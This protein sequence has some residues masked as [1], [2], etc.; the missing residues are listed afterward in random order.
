MTQHLVHNRERQAV[1]GELARVLTAHILVLNLGNLNDL[2]TRRAHTVARSHFLIKRIDRGV[3]RGFTVLLVG[4][5]ETRARLVANPDAEVLHGGGV[6]LEDL[7]EIRAI[8]TQ[9]SKRQSHILSSRSSKVHHKSLARASN[10]AARLDLPRVVRARALSP[11]PIGIDTYLVAS[12]DLTVRLLHLFEARH[13]IPIHINISS[14]VRVHRRTSRRVAF[15]HPSSSSRPSRRIAQPRD[16]PKLGARLDVI[17]RPKLHAENLRFGVGF[18][19]HVTAN[20]L[21]L[22]VLRDVD[23]THATVSRS[24]ANPKTLAHIRRCP[25]DAFPRRRRRRRRPHR[26]IQHADIYTRARVA[27]DVP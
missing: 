27:R 14:S 23:K 10:P 13:E 12:D 4:V 20:D 2:Q 6:R 25:D 24:I 3:H 16:V 22:V 9:R 1:L 7:C 15:H 5:V 17:E 18:R 26:R 8:Y 19:R 11:M 21:V